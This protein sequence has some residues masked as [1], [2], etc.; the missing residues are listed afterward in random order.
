MNILRPAARVD[1]GLNLILRAHAA[2][3]LRPHTLYQIQSLPTQ[4]LRAHCHLQSGYFTM[5]WI[6]IFGAFS[7]FALANAADNGT[8][9]PQNYDLASQALLVDAAVVALTNETAPTDAQVW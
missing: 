6:S 2:H 4:S 3:T 8:I 1:F 5:R 7:L 9:E